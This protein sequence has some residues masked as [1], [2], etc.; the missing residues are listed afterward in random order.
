MPAKKKASTK[1]APAKKTTKKTASAAKSTL[2]KVLPVDLKKALPPTFKNQKLSRKVMFI[3]L[4]ILAIALLTYKVG[5]WL[6][7]ATVNNKPISRFAVYKRMET[8]YGAQTLDDLVNEKILDQ[9]IKDSG[10]KITDD[11]VNQEIAKVEDQFQSLGGLDQALAQRGITRD[12]LK[13]Q[14]FTQ[15]AVEEILKDKVEP[16]EEAIQ[17]EYDTN[18]ADLYKGETLD[19]AKDTIIST[20]KQQNL[21]QAF[22]DWFSGVKKDVNVKKYSL[23]L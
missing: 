1:K 22:L 8:T 9:A 11:Q 7:P 2:K 5:P 3:S 17:K 4:G 20:L 12:E 19:Q 14:I 15:L 13:K 6:I 18:K 23:S 16:T 10:V 21:Q